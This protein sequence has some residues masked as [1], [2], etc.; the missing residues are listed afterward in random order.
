MLTITDIDKQ[1]P[2][3]YGFSGIQHDN[4]S[5]AVKAAKTLRAHGW[6]STESVRFIAA[7]SACGRVHSSELRQLESIH[8]SIVGRIA[9]HRGETPDE[10]RTAASKGRLTGAELI[11][12]LA[13]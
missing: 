8:P 7:T 1:A 3:V 5:N 10:T 2:Y 13:A 9:E 4:M 12:V 6:D 11:E